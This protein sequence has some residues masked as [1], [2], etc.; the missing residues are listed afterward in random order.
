MTDPRVRLAFTIHPKE[1]NNLTE[2]ELQNAIEKL[3]T[4]LTNPRVVSIG[5]IG[6]DFSASDSHPV[7]QEAAF[8]AQVRLALELQLPIV[9]HGRSA[10]DQ[11]SIYERIRVLLTKCG[12][13]AEYKLY[14]HCFTGSIIDVLT[15]REQFPRTIFGIAPISV[16]QMRRAAVKEIPLEF[17]VL[18]SDAPFQ[19]TDA[20]R[21]QA[22]QLRRE[23]EQS[24]DEAKQLQACH[25]LLGNPFVVTEVASVVAALKY[26]PTR[27]VLESTCRT[28]QEFFQAESGSY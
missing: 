27:F 8:R 14:V 22:Q 13:P 4:E 12:V 28:S 6:L 20:G 11:A 9:L 26:L 2:E 16:S 17:M 18:E 10:Q 7:K 3:R 15:W 19:L 1:A 23:A 5:E 24:S 25:H 21:D